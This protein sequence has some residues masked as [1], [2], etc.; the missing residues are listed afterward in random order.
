[1]RA[2]STPVASLLIGLTSLFCS[3]RNTQAGHTSHSCNDSSTYYN[4]QPYP[5]PD[6][7][8]DLQRQIAAERAAREQAAAAAKVEQEQ[9]A[10]EQAKRQEERRLREEERR[11]ALARNKQAKNLA[12][13]ALK[14]SDGFL[15]EDP[16]PNSGGSDTAASEFQNPQRSGKGP[17]VDSDGFLTE[18]PSTDNGLG[19]TANESQ[20]PQRSGKGPKVDSDGFLTED[21]STDNGLGGTA[22]ESQKAPKQ[23]Q[24]ITSDG[25]VAENPGK[26]EEAKDRPPVSEPSPKVKR[27]PQEMSDEEYKLEYNYLEKQGKVPIDKPVDLNP[28]TP[29]GIRKTLKSFSDITVDKK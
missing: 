26:P 29:E 5:T 12:T 16:S 25:F 10:E 15:T 19:G 8:A 4:S 21:P 18:D 14:T 28:S 3:A 9:R 13:K 6:Y 24:Q 23:R 20:K 1:V 2:I 22:N 27:K 7:E 11:Q 17:K